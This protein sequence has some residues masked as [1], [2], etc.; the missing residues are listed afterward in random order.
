MLQSDD[1]I[2][3]AIS[4]ACIL[5]VQTFTKLH[6]LLH[7]IIHWTTSLP[8]TLE[9]QS[10]NSN[11]VLIIT[12]GFS[13]PFILSLLAENF[14]CGQRLSSWPK[15]S[16]V[17]EDFSVPLSVE[18]LVT[19]NFFCGQRLLSWPKYSLVVEDFSV[20]L[21]VESIVTEIFCRD[22]VVRLSIISVDPSIDNLPGRSISPAHLPDR[23]DGFSP[24]H[25]LPTHPLR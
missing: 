11:I 2:I 5:L 6:Q 7:L 25:L 8:R 1:N 3:S 20:P 10:N 18:S 14:F 13:I 4:P 24:A 19:E 16:L 23:L 12:I 9:I 17:V 21:S 22:R 15:Y